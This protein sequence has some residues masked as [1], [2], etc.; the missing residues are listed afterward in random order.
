MFSENKKTKGSLREMRTYRRE[1]TEMWIAFLKVTPSQLTDTEL[2][3]SL[4]LSEG[5]ATI[6]TCHTATH[7]K[8]NS[9]AGLFAGGIFAR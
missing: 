8:A 7:N 5:F 1:Y 9:T 4:A 6:A 2:P 3:A